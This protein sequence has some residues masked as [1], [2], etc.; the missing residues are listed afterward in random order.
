M[1]NERRWIRVDYTS[2]IIHIMQKI[3][4]QNHLARIYK[5]VRYLYIRADPANKKAQE[6]A[7]RLD[8]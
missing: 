2:A 1:G 5:L 4:D 3:T 8:F 6:P 7:S